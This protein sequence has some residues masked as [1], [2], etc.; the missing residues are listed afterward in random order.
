MLQI[1]PRKVFGQGSYP[2]K[3]QAEQGNKKQYLRE[4]FKSLA[5]NVGSLGKT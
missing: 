5:E 2:D 4:P 1:H 3:R